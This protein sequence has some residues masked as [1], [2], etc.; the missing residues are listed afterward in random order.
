MT[1]ER[2]FDPSMEDELSVTVGETVCLLEEYEDE[3]CLVQRM[4]RMN[5]DKGV[6]PSLCLM[7]RPQVVPP[8]NNRLPSAKDTKP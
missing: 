6:V 3:W 2:S 4:G 5:A 8:S 1:V 7:E